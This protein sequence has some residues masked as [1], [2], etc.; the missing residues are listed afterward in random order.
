[1]GREGSAIV[2]LTPHED[3]YI[4]FLRVRKVPMEPMNPRAVKENYLD[5]IKEAASKDREIHEKG[6]R[7]AVSYVRAYKEHHCNFIFKLKDLDLGSLFTG[8]GLLKAPKMPEIRGQ[9]ANFVPSDVDLSILK[10]ADKNREKQRQKLVADRLEKAKA[11]K[12]AQSNKI[13]ERFKKSRE[14]EETGMAK[15][16]GK[17]TADSD[18]SDVSDDDDDINNEYKMIK[19]AKKQRLSDREL[20]IRLGEDDLLSDSD[21]EAGNKSAQAQPVKQKIMQAKTSPSSDDSD[22][23]MSDSSSDS[24]EARGAQKRSQGA[25]QTSR[26]RMGKRR[27]KMSS[28]SQKKEL[29]AKRKMRKAK[30][31]A[32]KEAKKLP[33]PAQ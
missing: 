24:S 18:S 20:H 4:E 28:W 33:S 7:A 22:S 16:R 30:R 10:F 2:Y 3:T 23:S 13:S 6:Q 29:L 25:S 32:R 27:Q 12:Q 26:G 15:K 14:P 8:L 9:V 17:P 31:H 21:T 11:E 19:K 5:Y 1:M